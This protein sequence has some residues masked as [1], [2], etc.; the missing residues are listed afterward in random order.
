MPTIKVKRDDLFRLVG[1][2]LSREEL[3]RTLFMLKSEL[4][5]WGEELEISVDDSERPDLWSAEGLARAIRLHLGLQRGAP[6]YKVYPSTYEV[7]NEEPRIRPYIVAA[8]VKGVNL[9]P[10]GLEQLIQL[11]EKIM[12]SYGRRRKRIAIGTSRADLIHFPITY[13]E[14]DPDA[15]SFVPLY[16]EEEMTLREVLEKTE[17]GREY[18]FLLEGAEKFPVLLDA[19]ERVVT[20][21][22]ILNS[23][24]LGRITE[25]THDIFVDVT[26]THLPSMITALNVVV[27]A[28]VERGGEV[29]EVKVNGVPYPD[30]RPREVEVSEEYLRRLGGY[31]GDLRDP[32]ERAGYTVLSQNPLRLLYPAYRGDI[33]HP[34]DV[35]E[36]LLSA[37]DYNRLEPLIPNVYTQGGLRDETL[38]LDALR[39]LMIGV[40]AEE[41]QT[42]TLT[43]PELF[44]KLGLDTPVTLS[45]PVSKS[46]S[47]L[48]SSL[49][50][51]L[52][53]VL[54]KNRT[55]PY[56]QRLFEVGE[57]FT[58]QWSI[59]LGYVEAGREVSYTTARQ[60]L[61]FLL[62]KLELNPTFK[63]ASHP[64][65]I[66]GRVAA[67]YL[68]GELLGYVGEVK[69]EVL[70]H[71]GLIVPVAAFEIDVYKILSRHNRSHH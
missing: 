63:E 28:L 54:S 26:G 2:E 35:L 36:D 18:A 7:I 69:P 10:E 46:Y 58:P 55:L 65:F 15:Y 39:D 43:D 27:T 57:V 37:V 5:D 29:H 53:R 71:F 66:R 49:L 48:R 12:L 16:E 25:D 61:E 38:I 40:S 68:D 34:R 1:R 42:F 62:R 3:E 21:P 45:N 17:K 70:E 52:L 32:L 23:N 4:E 24:D 11:Q 31:K 59:S 47:A 20:F 22:P 14:V 64:L 56:P 13:T 67:V 41:I 8:V 44:R 9:G 33:R 30:L 19:S 51:H 50:P 60:A 6:V